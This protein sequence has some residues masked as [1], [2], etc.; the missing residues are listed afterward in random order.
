MIQ[1]SSTPFNFR[2]SIFDE[3]DE[4]ISSDMP[5]LPPYSSTSDNLDCT[6]I[7]LD[8]FLIGKSLE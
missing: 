1:H 8:N 2:S 6:F 4:N 5:P 3:D 7:D